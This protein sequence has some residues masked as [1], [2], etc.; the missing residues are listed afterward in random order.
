MAETTGKGSIFL[1]LIILILIVVLVGAI[2][3]P[4]QMWDKEEQNTEICHQRMSSLLNAELLYQKYHDAYCPSLDT[5]LAFLSNDLLRYQLEFVN[6]DTVLDVQ[7]IELVKNDSLVQATMDTIMADTTM[8]AILQTITIDYFL[9]RAMVG[10][11]K[12]HDARM[13]AIINPIL[14]E[15]SEDRMAPSMAI[16][17]LAQVRSAY[18]I[19]KVCALDDSLESAINQ[20]KPSLTMV[21]YLSK[22]RQYPDVAQKIDTHYQG[23]LDSLYNCPTVNKPYHI[24]IAGSTIVYS[25]IFC[26]VDSLDSLKVANDFWKKKIGGLTVQNHGNISEAKKSWE[27]SL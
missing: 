7:L 25:N 12:N 5:L 16:Q 23:F 24:E 20:I 21:H 2:M 27:E 3:I 26:P 6:L 18:D 17:Q 14:K 10:V 19:L 13:T 9:S 4:K 1:K 11:I 22:I 15:N 8:A